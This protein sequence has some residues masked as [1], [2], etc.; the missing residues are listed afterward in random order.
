MGSWPLWP[1]PLTLTFCKDIVSVNGNN[2]RKFQDD[3]MTGSL[4]KRCDRRTETDRRTDRQTD[5]QTD[6]QTEISVLRA[7]WS[8]L[9]ITFEIKPLGPYV[10][11]CTLL[12][13]VPVSLKNLSCESSGNL[14]QNGRK[15]DFLPIFALFGF[16][17]DPKMWP[18]RPIFYT[19]FKSSLSELKNLTV[20][21]FYKINEN[22]SF[23]LILVLF[24]AKRAWKYGRWGHNLCTSENI[25][26]IPV[27]QVSWSHVKNFF[28]KCPQT[29]KNPCFV[30]F[31][32][33]RI[34]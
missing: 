8:Q 15:P 16:I 27:N 33:I 10:L 23:D 12:K 19:L 21:A 9:K 18:L 14:L 30:L 3:T 31:L 26:N 25:L 7:A 22:L 28:R 20:C 4:S 1:W 32:I 6:R 5:G 2:S 34:H 29:C 13:V 17:K 11:H 24:G